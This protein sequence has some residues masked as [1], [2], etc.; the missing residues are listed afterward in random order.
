M[1]LDRERISLDILNGMSYTICTSHGLST[2]FSLLQGN[3]QN[4]IIAH[5]SRSSCLAA[6]TVRS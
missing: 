3:A 1:A 6:D 5:V 4:Q 2:A